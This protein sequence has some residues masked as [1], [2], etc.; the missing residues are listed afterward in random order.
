MKNI[1]FSLLMQLYSKAENYGIM[2]NAKDND[3][4][5][6]SFLLLNTGL[7]SPL[8]S[9]QISLSLFAASFIWCFVLGWGF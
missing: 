8:L 4:E 9:S 6:W 2:N 5:N 7:R 1:I 3:Q